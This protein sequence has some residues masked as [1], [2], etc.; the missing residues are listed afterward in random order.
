MKRKCPPPSQFGN[1][2]EELKKLKVT[3]RSKGSDYALK[4]SNMTDSLAEEFRE[5]WKFST[6]KMY[7]QQTEIVANQTAT[8]YTTMAK[9]ALGWLHNVGGRP[10]EDL[11]LKD[12]VPTHERDGVQIAFEYMHWMEFERGASAN[13]SCQR[14][15][16]HSD[17]P[18][19]LDLRVALNNCTQEKAKPAYREKPNS[20]L[21]VTFDLRAKPSYSEKPYSD[22]PAMLDLRVISNDCTQKEKAKPAY[23]EKL[24]SDLPVM[25]DL[26]A[27]PAYGEKPYN[28][29][30]VMLDLRA[31]PAYGEKPYSDLPVMLYLRV[32]L[33]N[34]SKKEKANPAYGEKPYSDLP[35]MLYLRVVLNNCSKKEKANPA[36]G[37]KPY[38][39]LPVMLDLRVILNNCSKKEKVASNVSDEELKWMSWPEYLKF[40]SELRRE[41][42]GQIDIEPCKNGKPVVPWSR[43]MVAMAILNKKTN[44]KPCLVFPFR[45]DMQRQASYTPESTYGLIDKE[46]SKHGT[47]VV[48]RSR[49]MVAMSL[50]YYLMA[51]ILSCIP[52][53][54]RT[55]RELVVGKNLIK[56]NA[57]R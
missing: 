53:R 36:Y 51:A 35:V 54:Q 18:I 25:F 12:L 39:D 5:L 21:P 50:Q 13:K 45:P 26:R 46:S 43:P 42:A 31:N 47:R 48:P 24:N 19:M 16:T 7:G 49:S 17:L 22:L 30:P 52:D 20:D 27:N 41:C 55:L 9:Q 37:E 23:R 6:V 15:K 8:N 3:S 38:S 14:P 10:L 56:D 28:D 11:S 34:C 57:G 32:V 33:N 44:S 40:V 29:L 4:D 2:G 1:K